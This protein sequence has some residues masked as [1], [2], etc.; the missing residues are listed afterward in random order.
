[1]SMLGISI[2]NEMIGDRCFDAPGAI[3][4]QMREKIKD[5]LLQDGNDNEQKDG[6]DAALVILNKKTMGAS[7]AMM[8]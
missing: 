7:I 2:L 8:R 1:M 4:G 6:M 5:L 3:L